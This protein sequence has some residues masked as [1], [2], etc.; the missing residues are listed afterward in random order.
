MFAKTLD[1]GKVHIEDLIEYK[2]PLYL[3]GIVLGILNRRRI[4]LPS[5]IYALWKEKPSIETEKFL[6]KYITPKTGSCLV[7]AGAH[8]GLWASYVSQKG[9]K[10]YAFEPS[11]TAFHELNRRSKKDKNIQAFPVALGA[12]NSTEK[13]LAA[14]SSLQGVIIH[15]KTSLLPGEKEIDVKVRTLDSFNLENVGVIKIDTEGYE[16]PILIGA[17]QTIQKNQPT[18]LIEVHKD[19]ASGSPSFELES[20]RIK[21]ILTCLGYTWKIH[22]R[23][24]SHQELQPFIIAHAKNTQEDN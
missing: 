16:V 19:G 6:K 8:V 7:D 10:V 15:K 14:A 18:L 22:Y 2:D 9:I 3:F 5:K 24:V 12:A 17:E 21:R 1:K 20:Q 13:L 23:R 4:P 11:P